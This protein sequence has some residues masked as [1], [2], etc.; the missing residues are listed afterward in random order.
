MCVHQ[1]LLT[2]TLE[3]LFLM[4]NCLK[5]VP[6]RSS[7]KQLE[8]EHLKPIIQLKHVMSSKLGPS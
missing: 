2:L 4:I 5:I 6:I 3:E 8:T 1:G 7:L